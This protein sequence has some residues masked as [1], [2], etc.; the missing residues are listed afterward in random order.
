MTLRAGPRTTL[1]HSFLVRVYAVLKVCGSLLTPR[2]ECGS[3]PFRA[4]RR[5]RVTLN[6]PR[7][8]IDSLPIDFCFIDSRV[9]FR[10]N[11]VAL[12]LKTNSFLPQSMLPHDDDALLRTLF[13]DLL[14]ARLVVAGPHQLIR[15]RRMPPTLD[16][17]RCS[18]TTIPAPTRSPARRCYFQRRRPRHPTSRQKRNLAS[19]SSS[20]RLHA[21]FVSLDSLSIRRASPTISCEGKD[22]L[23]FPTFSPRPHDSS[24]KL[25]SATRHNTSCFILKFSE[26][27]VPV[28]ILLSKISKNDRR[29]VM[30]EKVS[31]T[32]TEG[33][34]SIPTAGLSDDAI[35]LTPPRAHE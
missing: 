15:N 1:E 24:K 10:L 32:P 9:V 16:R 13:S 23:S 21:R 8:L 6:G 7:S 2:G 11:D 26:D 19:R 31:V 5:L 28:R 25:C 20:Y 27:C 22:F 14:G 35:K 29:N 30:R 34:G 17:E 4:A 33:G 12:V 3:L 18:P